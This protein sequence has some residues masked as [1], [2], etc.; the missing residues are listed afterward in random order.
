MA[1]LIKASVFT[2]RKDPT[3]DML[4]AMVVRGGR[5][6]ITEWLKTCKY[7]STEPLAVPIFTLDLDSPRIK[8]ARWHLQGNLGRE[9][10]I[11]ARDLFEGAGGR[12]SSS[13]WRISRCLTS[14]AQG[15]GR[16]RFLLA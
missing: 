6:Q 12:R 4:K 16:E 15:R 2:G 13:R 9:V 8:A 5:Q 10:G 3:M 7:T 14:A 11:M 1:N